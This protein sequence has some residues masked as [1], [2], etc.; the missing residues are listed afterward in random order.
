MDQNQG[1]AEGP[2]FR[3]SDLVNLSTIPL[4][5][6]LSVD[7]SVLAAAMRRVLDEAERSSEA[8]SGWSSYID[9]AE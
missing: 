5:E 3:E 4:A 8:I 2:S 1:E 6:L 7:H 9:A